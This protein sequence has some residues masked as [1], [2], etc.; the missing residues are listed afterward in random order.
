MIYIMQLTIVLTIFIVIRYLAHTWTNNINYPR[1]L[2][3]KPF[4]CE[5]CFSFWSLIATYLAVG[6]VFKLWVTL[7]VGIVLSILNAI[8]MYID[9]RNKIVKIDEI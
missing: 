8:A 7:I 5:K 2:D 3:Y 1:W 9:D 6:L 4:N